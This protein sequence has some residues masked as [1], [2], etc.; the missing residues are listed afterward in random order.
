MIKYYKL[1]KNGE[2]T[3]TPAYFPEINSDFCK[4]VFDSNIRGVT[5]YKWYKKL[6][7]LE[8]EYFGDLF[9]DGKEISLEQLKEVVDHRVDNYQYTIQEKIKDLQKLMDVKKNHYEDNHS[10]IEFAAFHMEQCVEAYKE[11]KYHKY[12]LENDDIRYYDD[13]YG[14]ISIIDDIKP[15]K[16]DESD[17]DHW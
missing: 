9:S 17:Y 1:K 2:I 10:S 6:L 15:I 12:I 8:E 13:H 14:W 11:Y 16:L 4:L 7:K 5:L 3:K